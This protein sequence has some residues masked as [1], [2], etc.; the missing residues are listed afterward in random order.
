[1]SLAGELIQILRTLGA[2]WRRAM[3]AKIGPEG[4]KTTTIPPLLIDLVVPRS[5]TRPTGRIRLDP[6]SIWTKRRI[7]RKEDEQRRIELEEIVYDFLNESEILVVLELV[8][9]MAA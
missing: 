6:R 2:E 4:E 7:E 9:K 1:M 5:P 3:S 8:P